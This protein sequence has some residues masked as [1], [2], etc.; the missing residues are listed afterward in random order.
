MVNPKFQ[1][2]TPFVLPKKVTLKLASLHGSI[3]IRHWQRSLPLYPPF[4]NEHIA[5]Q[6]KTRHLQIRMQKRAHITYTTIST[7]FIYF[8][9]YKQQVLKFMRLGKVQILLPY[10]FNLV[11]ET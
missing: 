5:L 2:H 8:L 11:N 10:R 3:Y 6:R 1:H 7:D 9:C 4:S